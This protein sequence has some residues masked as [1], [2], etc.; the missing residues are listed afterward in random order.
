MATNYGRQVEQAG[1]RIKDEIAAKSISN[2]LSKAKSFVTK[3]VAARY[4]FTTIVTRSDSGDTRIAAANDWIRKY[5][6]K[7]ETR[8]QNK[9]SK[10]LKNT[11]FM[12]KLEKDTYCFVSVGKSMLTDIDII[13]GSA[14]SS[15]N[16]SGG[17]FSS[18]DLKIYIFGQKSKKYHNQLG[19]ELEK[20]S[21]GLYI[22]NVSGAASGGSEYE[23]GR[24]HRDEFNSIVAKMHQRQM[25]TLFFNP[26]VKESI[27][28]HIDSFLRNE[29]VYKERD[30]LYKTGILMYG[31]PGTGKTSLASAIAT[32][33]KSSLIVIDMT[34]FRGLDTTTLS[35]SI[36]AD[37]NRYVILLE[38]ID[39]VF[40]KLD[41]TDQKIDKEDRAVIQKLLQ[42]LDSNSS[43][44]NVIFLATT[45]HVDKLDKA[46]MRDGRFDLKIEIDGINEQ[47]ASQM[48]KS[49]ELSDNDISII[50]EKLEASETGLGCINQSKL[51][52]MILNQIKLSDDPILTT[53]DYV[54]PEEEEP[55]DQEDAESTEFTFKAT[56][57]NNE[58]TE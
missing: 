13:L 15:R 28:E 45:N 24:R 19:R 41:R 16:D 1:V 57:V 49:F 5:D 12:F 50:M 43:P 31:N 52:N 46:I 53:D 20:C 39:C 11:Q 9:L 3:H 40:E 27:I 34:T 4:G 48:C 55:Q 30:L 6:S 32:Y 44:S 22:Y 18:T 29:P 36:N 35:Q 17:F 56:E 25:D 47:V 58:K 33:Y 10:E 14:A 37:D 21:E 7:F 2:V 23:E 42:F 54:G 26:G 8:L 38:D 51:Q